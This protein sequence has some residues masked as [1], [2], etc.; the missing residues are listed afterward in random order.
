M[1]QYMPLYKACRHPEINRPLTTLEY[2]K[3]LRH[4]RE[5]GITKGFMQE[6][7]TAEAK[8]IPNFNFEHVMPQASEDPETTV[9]K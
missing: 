8:F 9:V 4:A 5:L 3:V 7:K 2:Q 6:G 1:N